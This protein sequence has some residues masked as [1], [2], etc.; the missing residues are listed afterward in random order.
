M[1][2]HTTHLGVASFLRYGLGDAAHTLTTRE[3]E[4]RTV[5]FTFDDPDAR[6]FEMAK[7]FFS[8][9]GAPCTDSRVLLEANRDVRETVRLAMKTG[10]WEWEKANNEQ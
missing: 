4:G 8:R 10:R 2:Y 7:M 1:T 6:C 5:T 9:E 3:G